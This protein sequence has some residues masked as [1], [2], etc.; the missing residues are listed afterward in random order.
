MRS[1]SAAAGHYVDEDWTVG[2]EPMISSNPSRSL[3]TFSASFA[4]AT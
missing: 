2:D 1:A 3:G 4:A